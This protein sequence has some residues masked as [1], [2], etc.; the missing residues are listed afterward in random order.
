MTPVPAADCVVV[1]HAHPD[2]EAIFTGGTIA[3]LAADGVRVVVVFATAGSHD[4]A[5]ALAELRTTEAREACALLGVQRVEILGY[6]D[7]GLDGR[8]A[9]TGATACCAAPAAEVADRL[10]ALL[11]E[12]RATALVVYD[13]GGIYGHPDHLA[14][15]RWGHAAAD[16]AGVATVYECTVDREYLHFV[17]THLVGHAIESLLGMEVAATNLAPLGVPT[18]LVSTTVDVRRVIGIKRAAMAAHASQIAADSETLT[19]SAAT[20]DGV[21]G[22]E[23]FV[24]KGPHGPLE[25]H[26]F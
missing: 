16:A 5:D 14:V 1:L 7:S 18:V 26:A 19:M 23:W 3:L 12:E 22:F 11:H 8:G 25:R 4:P 24:R 13:E 9:V 21:Y 6:A 10:A 17:E 15:H 2:D 20:F